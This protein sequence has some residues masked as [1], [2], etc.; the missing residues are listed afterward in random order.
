MVLEPVGDCC[1]IGIVATFLK[2]KNLGLGVAG[3]VLLVALLLIIFQPSLTGSL[4]RGKDPKPIAM[5]IG[6]IGI[7][8]AGA[9]GLLKAKFS[10]PAPSGPTA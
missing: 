7:I 2:S 4:F 8:G 9:L 3:F 10:A 5:T 1:I 6:I